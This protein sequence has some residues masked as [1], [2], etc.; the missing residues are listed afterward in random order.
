MQC[1]KCQADVVDQ[2]S[3][4]YK[5]GARLTP[6][7]GGEKKSSPADAL[8]P[9]SGGNSNRDE[10]EQELW[11]ATYSPKAAIPSFAVAGILSLIA[12]VVLVVMGWFAIGWLWLL[13]A[14]VLVFA[15]LGIQL[16]LTRLS[17]AYRLTTQRLMHEV[18]LLRRVTNRLEVID[19]DD[20]TVEQG[21]IDRILGIGTIKL[22]SSDRT[23][24]ALQLRGVD[25]VREVAEQFD[26]ARRTERMRR[27]LHIEA[28]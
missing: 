6:S 28:I 4:C 5:C 2:A 21:L 25:N 18:G 11:K 17:T 14:I 15:G 26:N 9:R 10:P 22:T 8:R 24:P 16:L 7:D 13:L 27:G 20:V 3:F 12:I 1:P 23:H 19:I